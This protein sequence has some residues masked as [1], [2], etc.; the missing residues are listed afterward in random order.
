MI[1]RSRLRGSLTGSTTLRASSPGPRGDPRPRARER[2]RTRADVSRP[3]PCG[4][5]CSKR[6]V[7][8]RCRIRPASAAGPPSVRSRNAHSGDPA[9]G[10][11]FSG[12]R[13]RRRCAVVWTCSGAGSASTPSIGSCPRSASGSSDTTARRWPGVGVRSGS[14]GATSSSRSCGGARL[15]DGAD[16][17]WRGGRRAGARRRSVSAI[18]RTIPCAGSPCGRSPRCLPRNVE[19]R[20]SARYAVVPGPVEAGAHEARLVGSASARGDAGSS[21]T[22]REAGSIALEVGAT[23]VL[24]FEHDEHGWLL[25][26]LALDRER[27]FQRRRELHRRR[28]WAPGASD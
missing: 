12:R 2:R 16:A 3:R 24:R 21:A 18:A 7:R 1:N 27:R 15:G 20:R 10:S 8:T 17:R 14:D 4:S 5:V 6:G 28:L 19:Q 22:T 11:R 9:A 13:R 26:V 23:P 25:R